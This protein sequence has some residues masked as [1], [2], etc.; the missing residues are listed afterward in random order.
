MQGFMAFPLLCFDLAAAG[1]AVTGAKS[2]AA[3]RSSHRLLQHSSCLPLPA[4]AV[5]PARR[6]SSCKEVTLPTKLHSGR[7]PERLQISKR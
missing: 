5:H 6:T 4:T 1:Q 3:I 2:Q 7:S